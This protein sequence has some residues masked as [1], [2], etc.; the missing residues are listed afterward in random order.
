MNKLLTIITFLCFSSSI[1]AQQPDWVSLPEIIDQAFN[2][3]APDTSKRIYL[4]QRCAAQQLAM[5]TLVAELS[6]DMEKTF[7]ESSS[8]L[9]QAAAL[10]RIILARTRIGSSADAETISRMS[11]EA[12]TQLYE[13]YMGWANNNYLINGSYFENDEEFDTEIELCIEISN[14][15][16]TLIDS[17][18]SN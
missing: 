6:A 5:S 18:R 3:S 14:L 4:F 7:I 11:L 2:E 15:A 8:T 1:I 9:S 13:Q 10:E 17:T 16:R 12:I